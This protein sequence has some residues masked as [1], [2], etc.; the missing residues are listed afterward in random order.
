MTGC[1]I[2]VPNRYPDVIEPLIESIR[3]FDNTSEVLIVA[4]EHDGDYGHEMIRYPDKEFKYSKAVNLGIQW[5]MNTGD[6]PD[7]VLMNDDCR[8]IH[9]S[10]MAHLKSEM[11]GVQRVGIMSPLIKGGVGNPVQRWHETAKWWRQFEAIKLVWGND[12]VCFP[13]VMLKSEMVRQIGLLNENIPGYGFEDNDYCYRAR[14][15]GWWTAVTRRV[16]IQHGDGSS[17]LET[18]R[19]K[20]WSTSFARELGPPIIPTR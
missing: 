5:A 10:A 3:A 8:L 20:S 16:I 6:F 1:V 13:C 9:P 7:I 2:V 14:S 11:D 17:S 15:Y 19:G 4:H 12:P 18:G